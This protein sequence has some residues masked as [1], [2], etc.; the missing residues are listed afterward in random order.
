MDL[1]GLR[2]LRTYSD[3]GGLEEAQCE[4][5]GAYAHGDRGTRQDAARNHAHRFTGKK[6]KFRQAPANFGR[7]FG[8]GCRH[9]RNP[10][11]STGRQI[12]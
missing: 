6:S 1:T 10:R 9:G 12:G 5:A 2:L 7:S 3:T 11:R 4:S 8:I